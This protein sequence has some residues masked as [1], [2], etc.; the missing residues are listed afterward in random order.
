MKVGKRDGSTSDNIVLLYLA[1]AR[2][3]GSATNIKAINKFIRN[4]SSLNIDGGFPNLESPVNPT[5][6][7]PL[8][9]VSNSI[10]NKKK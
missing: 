3:R 10:V 7:I 2:K 6:G 4:R 9:P 8:K 1:R 5:Q